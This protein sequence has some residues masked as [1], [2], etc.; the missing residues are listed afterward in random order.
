MAIVTKKSNPN[1][2]ARVL[3]YGMEGVGKSTLGAKSEKPVFIT[4]EGGADQLTDSQGNPIEQMSDVSTWADLMAAVN[5]L[6][7][8]KHDFKT[9]VLDS[10]DW[11]EGLAHKAIIGNSGKTITTVNG[12]YGSGY[13][14]SQNMHQALIEQLKVLRE[15]KGM[16]IIVTA[17]AHV[18][19]VKDPEM[20]ESYDSFEIKCH[21]LVSSIW[22]EWVDGLFFVRFRTFTKTEE[23]AAK[24]KAF[25]DGTRVLYAQKTPAFQAK[26][27]YGMPAEMDFTEGFWSEFMKYARKGPKAETVKSVKDEIAE[28]Y[29]TITQEKIKKGVEDSMQEA[30][31][32]LT[33]LIVIRD[34]LR[35][36][37]QKKGA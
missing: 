14:Q 12:G 23:G 4:P 20:T 33:K 34:R 24:A 18:K 2:P 29:L 22:R 19:E 16:N 28:M 15:K 6:I 3:V 27:R 7:T 17:H 5:A 13:R 35:E 30:G 11:I 21:E 8:E 37:T 36:V 32:D 31:E 25:T 10:A 1:N 9:L 26:N